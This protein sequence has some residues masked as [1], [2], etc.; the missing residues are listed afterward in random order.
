NAFRHAF[1]G[2]RQGEVVVRARR[3]GESISLVVSDDGVGLPE[4]VDLKN[5]PTLGMRLVAALARQLGARVTL[6]TG[7]GA[8]ITLTFQPKVAGGRR[9]APCKSAGG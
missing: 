4:S 7:R 8:E 2:G 3:E 9:D 6:G 5:A 1:P